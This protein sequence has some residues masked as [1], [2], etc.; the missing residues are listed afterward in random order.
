MATNA[1]P[2][3]RAKLWSLAADMSDGFHHHDPGIAQNTPAKLDAE[4]Q[5]AKNTEHAFAKAGQDE[6][7]ALTARNTANSN[8]K[9]ALFLAKRQLADV[10]GAFS[11]IFPA[12]TSEILDDIPARLSLL[13][14]TINYL[15][16][17]PAQAVEPKNFTEAK[18]RACHSA[19]ESARSALNAAVS[20]RVD[21]K[22]QRDAAD[23][24]LRKRLSALTKEL[25]NPGMFTPDDDRWYAFGLVPP[26]GILRPGIAPD[27]LMLRQIGPGSVRA[28]WSDTPR[29]HRF[30]PFFKLEGR[31][32]DFIALPAED[33]LDLLLENLP[34]T[35]LLKFYVI[36]T[37]PAGDSPKS[38]VVE[39]AL[40]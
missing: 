21:A 18:L 37:N 14:K 4:L 7:A 6:N 17:H 22:G 10:P 34:T 19:L 8:V 38:A 25:G 32:P 20:A 36:A 15:K 9:A 33:D 30:R 13:E 26:A 39:L 12:G 24:T 23:E 31:D 2:D 3:I 27:N 35:G 28:A 29:S 16:D 40:G 11:L 1:L 5:A